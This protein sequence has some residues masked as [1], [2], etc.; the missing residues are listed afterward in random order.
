MTEV[1]LLIYC[2]GSREGVVLRSW[3]AVHSG[4]MCK[5]WIDIARSRRDRY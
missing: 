5:Y 2:E 4:L 3:E 1:V